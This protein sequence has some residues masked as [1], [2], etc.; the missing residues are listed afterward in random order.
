MLVG[1]WMPISIFINKDHHFENKTTAY[2]L[3]N[4]IGWWNSIMASDFNKDGKLDFIIGNLGLNTK[5]KASPR[6]TL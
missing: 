5:H 6:T 3:Q 2:N 1:H 4:T